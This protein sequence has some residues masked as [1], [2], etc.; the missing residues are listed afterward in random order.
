[1]NESNTVK[2]DG[3]VVKTEND[4]VFVRVIVKS[5]CASCQINSACSIS[6]IEEKIIEVKSPLKHFDKGEKVEIEMKS[7]QGFKALFFGYFLPFLIMLISLI[8]VLDI[9]DNEGISAGASLGFVAIYYV[10][11]YFFKDQMKKVFKYELL[12]K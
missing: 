6:D 9:S 5:A 12:R 2:H 8:V 3:I 7:S 11:L 1:M 4:I 10:V